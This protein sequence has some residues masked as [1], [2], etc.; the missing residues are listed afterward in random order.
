[1]E[2]C[3]FSHFLG[4]Y[5]NFN[6]VVVLCVCVT[7]FRNFFPF[8]YG[9]LNGTL[10]AQIRRKVHRQS[11]KYM[12]TMT[13]VLFIL[14]HSYCTKHTHVAC[15][16]VQSPIDPESVCWSTF[17]FD[18]MESDISMCSLELESSSEDAKQMSSSSS[19]RFSPAPKK[20]LSTYYR[21][22]MKGEGKRYLSQILRCCRE[23][24]SNTT[25]VKVSI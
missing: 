7:R 8:P 24:D 20:I 16:S 11:A 6:F 17:V 12:K 19:R 10:S 15:S 2:C 9:K 14:T 25:K 5:K 21:A 1:M 22:G 13:T 4:D 18:N 3:N 23:I